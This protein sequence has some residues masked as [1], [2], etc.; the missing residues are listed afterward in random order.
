MS[1]PIDPELAQAR[2]TDLA[3][4]WSSLINGNEVVSGCFFT[5][6]R[7]GLVLAARNS[8]TAAR[9]GPVT[10][11]QRLVVEQVLRGVCQGAIA[12]ELGV[13]PSTVALRAKKGLARLGVHT[14]PLQ[15]HPLLMLAASVATIPAS[16]PH[17]TEEPGIAQTRVIAVPRPELCL[18]RTMPRAQF[19]TIA[20][21]VEG[22]T[23]ASIAQRRRTATRTTANQL[24]SAFHTLR[25][26]G[27]L[28]L[29][30]R[31]FALSGWLPH[32][33]GLAMDG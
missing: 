1:R 3:S 7:C 27:R 6:T 17:A 25:V 31:L 14:R 10:E 24:A 12:I 26:S 18:S 30:H 11:S 13:A 2:P 16:T 8:R 21:L 20:L 32:P 23:Y 9:A 22:R 28:Q 4:V 33:P 29:I 15:A 5:D 19:E